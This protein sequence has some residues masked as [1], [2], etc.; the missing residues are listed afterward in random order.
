MGAFIFYRYSLNL[1]FLLVLALAFEVDFYFNRKRTREKRVELWLVR[2]LINFLGVCLCN[3]VYAL[4]KY[5][6]TIFVVFFLFLLLS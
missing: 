4:N 2:K 3:N 6:D 1:Q 5:S